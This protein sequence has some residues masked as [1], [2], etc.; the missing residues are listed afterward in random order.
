MKNNFGE[1]RFSKEKI[2]EF[3][4]KKGFYV[5]LALCVLIV[6]LTA[7]FISNGTFIN[8]DRGYEDE[9]I[10]SGEMAED[11]EDDT[12]DYVFNDE[13]DLLQSSKDTSGSDQNVKEKSQGEAVLEEGKEDSSIS[14]I[15][16][17][18]LQDDNKNV[19]DSLAENEMEAVGVSAQPLQDFIMPVY[20]DITFDYAMDRLVYSKTLEEWR[21]HSGIDIG[22]SRGTPVKVVADGVVREIKNDPRFGITIIVEHS[23][24]IR[25]VYA[26]LAN[27][28][29]VSPN[30]KVKQGDV[31]SSIGNTAIFESA[32]PAHLHFEVLKDNKPVDPKKYLPIK[33]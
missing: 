15:N 16:T 26:N 6:G 2:I 28:D 22:S 21:T 30:Q 32:E 20:G 12:E 13:N 19:P 4:E 27:G 17:D 18:N 31:I 10:I 8:S 24:N 3:F 1:K 33:D 5:V 25:T 11:F 14:Y 23:G 9:E 29:T 7:V